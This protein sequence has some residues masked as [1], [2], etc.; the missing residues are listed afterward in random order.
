M[1]AAVVKIYTTQRQFIE[2][3]FG[4]VPREQQGIGSGVII[5]ANNGHVLTNAHVV[6]GAQEIRVFLKDGRDFEGEVVGVSPSHDLAVL[7]VPAENLQAATL[8]DVKE[9]R[10]GQPVVAIG[11]PLGLDYT[12][13]TGVISALNR[14]LHIEEGI[15]P[16]ENLIQTD[17]AINPG[18][19]GG[20]LVDL[21]G[22]VVG[23]NTAV[24]RGSPE[25]AIEGLGFAI[26][27]DTAQRI[28]QQIIEGKEP[29]R[30]GIIGGTLTPERARAIEQNTHIPLPV[31]RGVFVTRVIPGT[32][33]AQAGLREADIIAAVGDEPVHTIEELASRVERAGAG[34]TVE[35]LVA[36]RGEMYLVVVRL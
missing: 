17:A 12:V 36:R 26:S 5:D 29:V 15:P 7:K 22:R 3:L 4:L 2:S 16:L 28:A 30:L 23:I 11:N 14:T 13:T 31:R 27:V 10:V 21:R 18:N 32:P 19:S 34:A 33:A 8:A 1:C 6:A 25:L 24:L 20:P 35:L 9:L